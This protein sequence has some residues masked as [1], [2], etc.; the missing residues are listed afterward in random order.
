MQ[1]VWAGLGDSVDEALEHGCAQIGQVPKKALARGRRHRAINLKPCEDVV[2]GP[3]GRDT[4]GRDSTAAPRQHAD[5]AFVLAK[6]PDRAAVVGR[7]DA[8]QAGPIRGLERRDAIRLF[9]CGW[10]AAR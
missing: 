4:T 6:H 10:G 9:W 3:H 7:D 5:T 2:D 8:L 1:A